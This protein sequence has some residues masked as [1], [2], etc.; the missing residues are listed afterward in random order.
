MMIIE[1]NRNEE[2]VTIDPTQTIQANQ[3]PLI[4]GAGIGK[5]EK[6]KGV[7]IM[8]HIILTIQN[9]QITTRIIQKII[10]ISE[11]CMIIYINKINN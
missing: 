9:K 7:L 5:L 8:A 10:Q 6:I 2:E 4:E 11:I 1:G 3:A